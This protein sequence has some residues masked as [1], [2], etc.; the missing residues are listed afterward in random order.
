MYKTLVHFLFAV[1][2]AFCAGYAT[3]GETY[4][5]SLSAPAE[6]V[7]PANL[8]NARLPIENPTQMTAPTLNSAMQDTLLQIAQKDEVYEKYCSAAIEANDANAQ[9]ALGLFYASGN[10][11]KQDKHLAALMFYLAAEQQHPTALD[12]LMQV[13]GDPALANLPSCTQNK[14]LKRE[15]TAHNTPLETEPLSIHEIHQQMTEA[16]QD[17]PPMKKRVFKLANKIAS[18]VGVD[19][20]LV[21]AFISTESAFNPRATSNKKAQ[22]LMQL[23]PAT[24]SRFN[25]KNPYNPEENIRGGVAYLKWLLAYFKGDVTLVA[26]AYNAG[27]GAVNRFGG[28]PPYAETRDYVRKIKSLYKSDFHPYDDGLIKDSKTTKRIA[29]I[30]LSPPYPS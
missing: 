7:N 29:Q 9:F 5:M 12:W 15:R 28:I 3:A 6:L 24:A 21:M 30:P 2:L 8:N 17:A 18:K 27:E 25:V 13:D 16:Y 23:I 20:H 22:G 4:T 1:L 26:A 11:A 10:A 19:P 14:H